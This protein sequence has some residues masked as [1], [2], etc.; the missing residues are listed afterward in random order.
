MDVKR[1]QESQNN[2]KILPL[3]N[4]PY[5]LINDMKPKIV[6]HLQD[7]NGKSLSNISRTA[8]CRCGASKN[9]PFCDGTHGAIGFSSSNKIFSDNRQI[10]K[11]KMKSYTGKNIIIHDNR[12][13][14]S[15][16]GECVNNLSSVFR[17]DA[18]PWID[19]DG[20]SVEEIIQTIRKCPSGALSYSID[21]I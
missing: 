19:P 14:C 6:E 17:L 7:E 18:K 9:K 13:I 15:H 5:Y 10:P 21:Y 11:D 2:P 4:G 12:R 20:A 1:Q 3:S 8:L 16:A